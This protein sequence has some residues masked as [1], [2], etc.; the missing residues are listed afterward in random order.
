METPLFRA[1]FISPPLHP[2]VLDIGECLT[3]PDEFS[4]Q[5]KLTGMW[6]KQLVAGAV[7]GAVSRTGTAPLDRLKVFM[8]VRGPGETHPLPETWALEGTAESPCLP[9]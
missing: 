1:V 5:E 4:E 7:A 9:A 3:I 2:Q 6:W 8:Q